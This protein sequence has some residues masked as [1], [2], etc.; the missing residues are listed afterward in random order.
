MGARSDFSETTAAAAGR[1]ADAP[2]WRALNALNAALR[3]LMNEAPDPLHP[4]INHAVSEMVRYVNEELTARTL[5]PA[6]LEEAFASALPNPIRSMDIKADVIPGLALD[7][8]ALDDRA[9]ALAAHRADIS[10]FVAGTVGEPPVHTPDDPSPALLPPPDPRGRRVGRVRERARVQAYRNLRPNATPPEQAEALA[11]SDAIAVS[12]PA[13]IVA[14]LRKQ[15]GPGGVSGYIAE[16]VRHQLERDRLDDFLG[17]LD[18]EYGPVPEASMARA[19][20]LWPHA[21]Q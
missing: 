13:D 12:L 16:A 18:D 5:S 9:R 7:P 4:L 2:R 10:R 14:E 20:E 8:P 19:E 17:W 6:E 1:P 11:A 15:A 21:A 3:E